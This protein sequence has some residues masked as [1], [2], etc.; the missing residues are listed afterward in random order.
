VC[1]LAHLAGVPIHAT[2]LYSIIW[3]AVTAV[4]VWRLWSVHA[5][6]HLIAGVYLIVSGLG[7][8]VEESYR[9]EPQ[10]PIISGLRIYQWLALGTAVAGAIITALGS[11]E[12]APSPS[13]NTAS[14]AAGVL[15]GLV[16]WAALG[17]DFPESNKRFSRLA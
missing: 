17:V 8:F 5:A 2:P 13:P 4:V 14:L 3:N 11:S 15:F 1:K 10:T 16:T 9:G 6:L 7:R 12:A